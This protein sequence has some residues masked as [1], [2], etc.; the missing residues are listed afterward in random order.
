MSKNCQKLYFFQKNCQK[1]SFCHH[2]NFLT[3]FLAFNWQYSGGS[4]SHQH[5]YQ[6]LHHCNTCCA[7]CQELLIVLSSCRVAFQ[8]QLSVFMFA[9]YN[10]QMQQ[11]CLFTN[12]IKNR[13]LDYKHVSDIHFEK[14]K[15][16]RHVIL[17]CYFIWVQILH[18]RVL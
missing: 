9:V 1:L 13:Q 12:Y 18:C 3:I 16:S 14:K 7:L 8:F 5:Q 17:V 2:D 15:N 11:I 10:C 6:L 4:A